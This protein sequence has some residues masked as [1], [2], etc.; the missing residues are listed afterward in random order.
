MCTKQR[1]RTNSFSPSPFQTSRLSLSLSLSSQSTRCS[2]IEIVVG[3]SQCL[4]GPVPKSH[5]KMRTLS[6]QYKKSEGPKCQIS[7]MGDKKITIF[8][9][10]KKKKKI[11]KKRAFQRILLNSFPTPFTNY[12][13]EKEG[14]KC[15]VMHRD[16][17]R[18]TC[19]MKKEKARARL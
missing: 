6:A 4:S 3:H 14:C 7:F 15:T 16:N 19:M 13:V 2:G 1:I 5:E 18:T 17:D 9:V 11:R 8:M 10:R 12:A